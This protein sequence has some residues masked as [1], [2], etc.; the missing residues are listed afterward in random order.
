MYEIDSVAALMLGET[1]YQKKFVDFYNRRDGGVNVDVQQ[2]EKLQEYMQE[3]KK[4]YDEAA[5]A[6]LNKLYQEEAAKDNLA[7]EEKMK[8]WQNETVRTSKVF[9]EELET[10]LKEAYRQV[11]KPYP[12]P[13]VASNYYTAPISSTGWKNLDR[14][15]IESTSN[16][17]TLNYTDPESGK[18]A[19][20]K[21]LPVSVKVNDVKKYD[22]VLSYLLPDKLSSFQLMK[23]EGDGFKENLNEL[24]TYSLV[25]IGFKGD[26][27]FYSEIKN[28]QAQAYTV[29]L[30][31]T[32]SADLEKKLNSVSALSQQSDVLR[33]I[34]YQVFEQKEIKR[35]KIIEKREEF[36]AKVIKV[37]FPCYGYG[38]GFK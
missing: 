3:K 36:R 25:T 14:Y 5:T 21:Y 37:I 27:V 17:T 7:G 9:S 35:K 8:H 33:E 6:A 38:V 13:P 2:I 24:F 28:I 31:K 26:E 4:I 23:K 19:I 30:S 16:R 34:N 29:D 1:Q 20:I 11:G 18:K 15:V 32:T 12:T 22:R 10:N